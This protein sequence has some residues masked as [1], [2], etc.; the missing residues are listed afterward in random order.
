MQIHGKLN[1]AATGIVS[2]NLVTYNE[3]LE[4]LLGRPECI[5][6]TAYESPPPSGSEYE[7]IRMSKELTLLRL[8]SFLSTRMRKRLLCK[9]RKAVVLVTMCAF[10]S[11]HFFATPL[12]AQR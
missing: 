4:A 10:A 11:Q 5:S 7:L 9:G 2:L 8:I 12:T 3:R 6:M 1:R